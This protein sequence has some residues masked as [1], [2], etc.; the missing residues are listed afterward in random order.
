[1]KTVILGSCDKQTQE[2]FMDLGV[3][4]KKISTYRSTDGKL[5]KVGDE[6]LMEVL[7]AWEQWTGPAGGF[8]SAIGVDH[9]KM[10]SLIGRAKRLKQEGYG[11]SEF[12]EM[13][14]EGQNHGNVIPLLPCNG[15]EVI[16]N[17]GKIIR[18]S[19]MDLLLEFLKKAA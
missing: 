19:Q 3:I 10:A 6:L 2:V 15:A 9:R 7:A 12:K 4:K 17:D 1:M 5:R 8:Y 11:I 13:E 16:W 14:V 18:F